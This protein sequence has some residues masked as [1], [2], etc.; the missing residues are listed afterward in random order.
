MTDYPRVEKLES[1]TVILPVINE[2]KSLAKRRWRSSFVTP[3]TASG[4]F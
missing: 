1:V 4:S 2:T 3:E